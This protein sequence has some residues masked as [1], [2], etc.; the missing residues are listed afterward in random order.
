MDRNDT[1]L[2]GGDNAPGFHNDEYDALVE[3]FLA[4]QTEE[5]AYDIMWQMEEILAD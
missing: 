1:L 5:E 3:Q 2:N 4:A